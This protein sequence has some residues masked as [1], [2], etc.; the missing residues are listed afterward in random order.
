L[1]G[2]IHRELDTGDHASPVMDVDPLKNFWTAEHRNR[3]T[4]ELI[5]EVRDIA[6]DAA[7]SSK[8]KPR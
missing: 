4:W 8:L 3:V 5:H 7:K 6:E 2:A 1:P